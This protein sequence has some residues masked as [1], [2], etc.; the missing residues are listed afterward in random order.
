MNRLDVLMG[1]LCPNGVP[2][3]CLEDCCDLEK[4]KTPIQK[5]IPGEYPLVVTTSERKSSSTYQFS[6]PAVCVPLVSSRGHGVACLNQVYYQE[7]KFALGNILCGITPQENSGLSTKFLFYYLNLKKD[8]L[9][10]PLMKG[11]ANVSLTV[12]ALKTVR[13]AIPPLT[14]QNEIVIRLQKFEELL[15]A[16][17]AE[18]NLR[19]KQY[20]YYR[21]SVLSFSEENVEWL[22]IGEVFDVRNGYT[23][24]KKIPEYWENGTI[25]WFRMEDIRTNGRILQDAIQHV[26]PS[27]I[28]KSGLIEK[29]S[30]MIA[31]TATLGEHALIKTDYMS[32]QQLTNLTIKK[33]YKGIVFPEFA[34][35]YC[36]IIDEKCES[37][38]NYSGGIP[39]V[40]QSKFKLLPFPIPAVERQREIVAQLKKMDSLCYD[41]NKGIP[42]EIAVRQKQYEYYRDR[43][44]TFKEA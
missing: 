13:I 12:N 37:V 16:Y 4:G 17:S 19:I 44:L 35:F 32:N 26:H 38:A 33:K 23:P 29:D 43:L 18:L 25:P 14:V 2:Y 5:A 11:G 8:S 22:S 6:K 10:V 30:I 36:F 9:I 21:D 28:K 15:D 24:S 7:G 1:S 31:T 27:G 40:D 20:E 42:A 39:I 34:F 3:K 41:T